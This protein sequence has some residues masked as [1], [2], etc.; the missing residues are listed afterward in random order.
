MLAS[1]NTTA[2]I[3]DQ[4]DPQLK[5]VLPSGMEY[6]FSE[7]GYAPSAADDL[8]SSQR[9]RV[10]SHADIAFIDMPRAVQAEIG[11]ERTKTGRVIVSDLSRTGI[12]ILF[13]E[14][15]FPLETFE[16]HFQGRVLSVTAVRC[17][18]LGD[19]CFETGGTVTSVRTLPANQ[20][21]VSS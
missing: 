8:R 12:G 14:Q 15:I 18:R 11:L 21:F 17:R 9:L 20:P 2:G 19:L 7:R 10:R 4:S 16:V 5:V 1:S 13:H 6:F 3:A